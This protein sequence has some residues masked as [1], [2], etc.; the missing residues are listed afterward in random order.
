MT[1]EEYMKIA[2][3]ISK[4]SKYPYGAIIVKDGKIIDRSDAQTKI[5]KSIFHH[6]QMSA[7]EDALQNNSLYG[8]LKGCVMYSSCE[9]CMM[10]LENIMYSEIDKLVYGIEIDAS[11]IYYHHIEDFSVLDIIKRIKPNMKIVGGILRNE[12]LKVINDYNN[13][14]KKDDEKYI[15][16]AIELSSKSYYPFGAIIVRNGKIIGKSS[17]TVPIKDTIYTHAE[18]I[19]IESAVLNIKDSISRGNLHECT[20]YTSCEPC[21]MCM[22]A[23][24]AEGISR[25][26]YAATIEDSNNYFIE[27]YPVSLETIIKRSKCHIK[28]VPELHRDKAIEVLKERGTFNKT[29]D[30]IE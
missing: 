12:A 6:A 23:I 10:C 7:I 19:A 1:D 28:I 26:V 9:P 3:E 14:L 30:E 15:D 13:K 2:I 8:G 18:L 5:N 21:M 20:L 17:D 24:L 22:E 29:N 4:N 16:I 27:E 25:V 11:N